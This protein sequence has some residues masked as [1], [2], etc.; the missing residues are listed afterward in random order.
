MLRRLTELGAAATPLQDLC[1]AGF[2]LCTSP[3]RCAEVKQVPM[4]FFYPCFLSDRRA[5]TRRLT[6]GRATPPGAAA[7][8]ARAPT[9][10]LVH[11]NELA[12]T[13]TRSLTR[14]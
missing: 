12:V 14:T 1:T 2:P 11:P 9:R 10:P 6:R 4:P 8:Y 7:C 5:I 3:A 13:H